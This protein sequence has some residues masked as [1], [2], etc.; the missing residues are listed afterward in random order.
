MSR[1]SSIAAFAITMVTCALVVEIAYRRISSVLGLAWKN[2]RSQRIL[3][4]ELQGV[5]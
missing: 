3:E 4:A 2:C 5:E 1:V